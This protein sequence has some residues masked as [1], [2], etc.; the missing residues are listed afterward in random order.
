[1]MAPTVASLMATDCVPAY[2]P[3][4]RLNAGVA[5]CFAP[6]LKS[7]KTSSSPEIEVDW[8]TPPVLLPLVPTYT[9]PFATVGTVNFTAFPAVLPVPWVLFQSS[10]ATLVASYAC[11]T[12]G[13]HVPDCFVQ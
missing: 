2:I 10:L 5:A 3:D 13:P 7:P 12:V 9:F 8:K 6:M 1:M 11:S 4:V